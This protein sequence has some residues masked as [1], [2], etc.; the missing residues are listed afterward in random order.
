MTIRYFVPK[1][2]TAEQLKKQYKELAL[3]H[4]PDCG[5]NVEKMKAINNEYDHLFPLLKDIHT[6][7]D[8]EQYTS[9]YASTESAEEWKDIIE[10]LISLHMQNV[11]IEII[12]RFVWLNGN[13]KPYKD[14]LK[15]MGYR[16][17][18][19]KFAWYLAPEGY[20]RR[21]HKV[22]TMND[23]R[24]MYGSEQVNNNNHQFALMA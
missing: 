7:K 20:K 23:I 8:N 11:L 13:T 17:S 5:G 18:S 6:N 22:Y 4:H 15:E 9:S 3:I 10:S 24:N 21:N 1:P 19:N 14:S 12:G 2:E 16:W